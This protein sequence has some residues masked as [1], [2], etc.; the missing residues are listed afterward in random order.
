[1]PRGCYPNVGAPD[2]EQGS[3]RFDPSAGPDWFAARSRDWLAR[4]AQ[5]IGGCCGT[6]PAHIRALRAALPPV[7]LE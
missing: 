1:V 2:L 5:I 4:G 3:W 7:L 6:G